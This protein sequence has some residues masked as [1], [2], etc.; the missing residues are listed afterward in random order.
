[1]DPEIL[2]EVKSLILRCRA[3]LLVGLVSLFSFGCG[4]FVPVVNIDDKTRRELSEDV[5]VYSA[6]QLTV[7]KHTV[8]APVEAYSCRNKVYEPEPSVA[9]ATSQLRLYARNLGANGITNL[10]C[11][12]EGLN[13]GR[14]CWAS[15]RCIAT[16]IT[17]EPARRAEPPLASGNA[18]QD[19]RKE[20]RPSSQAENQNRSTMPQEANKRTEPVAV[21]RPGAQKRGSSGTGFT[22]APGLVLT[23]QHVVGECKRV[24][25]FSS[26]GRRAGEVIASDGE[27]DV[28]LLRVTGLAGSF[29]RFRQPGSV[30][31]G[32][33]AYAFGFPLT[34]LLSEGGNFATG[35]VSG[36]RGIR[37]SASHIQISI[38][39]QAG[40]SGGAVL[41][42]SGNVLGVVVG[43][44]NAAA[45]ANIIGDIPQ[46]VNFAVS[47]SAI[48]AFF[49]NNGIEPQYVLK[50]VEVESVK[51]AEAAKKF[52]HRI[53]CAM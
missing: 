3:C 23:N 52:S 18:S 26:D 33:V 35:V 6:A 50:G 41:D 4:S 2:E 53:V 5:R 42:S 12:R 36:L 38:P 14:N 10:Y 34:G 16:A 45:V 13:Y 48:S 1:M 29:P 37:E 49:Q 7:R 9:D 25:V 27:T 47:L 11:D 17:V 28:A 43:K 30:M 22:I 31:L 8:L 40:N 46:N 20:G 44:L 39:V 21:A 15:V 32:E 51:V 24:D 19:D